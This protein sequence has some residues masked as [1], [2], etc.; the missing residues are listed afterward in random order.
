MLHDADR[1]VRATAFV[2]AEAPPDDVVLEV[3]LESRVDRK[4]PVY[5]VELHNLLDCGGCL[6]R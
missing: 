5:K 3:V 4:L 2:L 6:L 1:L